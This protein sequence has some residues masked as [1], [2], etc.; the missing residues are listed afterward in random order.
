[1][2]DMKR[3]ICGRNIFKFQETRHVYFVNHF[4]FPPFTSSREIPCFK[5]VTKGGG[6]LNFNEFRS[7]AE[8]GLKFVALKVSH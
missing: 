1:M 7:H 5:W 6:K 8:E 2:H 3:N 4:D